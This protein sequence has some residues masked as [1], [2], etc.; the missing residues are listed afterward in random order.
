MV[1]EGIFL[2]K[3]LHTVYIYLFKLIFTFI[4]RSVCKETIKI[5]RQYTKI[6]MLF[7]LGYGNYLNNKTSILI[8]TYLSLL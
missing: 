4:F 3:Y 5:W 6:L 7:V 1:Y 8:F 2:Y